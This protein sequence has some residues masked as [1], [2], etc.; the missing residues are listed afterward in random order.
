MPSKRKETNRVR[1]Q[2]RDEHIP[3]HKFDLPQLS[4]VELQRL[5]ED[6]FKRAWAQKAARE[7]AQAAAKAAANKSIVVTKNV[8]DLEEDE[9]VDE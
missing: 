3:T 5:R 7:A 6:C 4:I 8:T 9:F 2:Q 1:K